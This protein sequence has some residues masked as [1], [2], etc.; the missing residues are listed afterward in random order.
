MKVL[1]AFIKP[2]E[3]PKRSVKIKVRERQ[4]D[5]DR[6]RERE[7]GGGEGVKDVFSSEL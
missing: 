7:G 3:A 4:R 5:R 6:D 2:F 1:K